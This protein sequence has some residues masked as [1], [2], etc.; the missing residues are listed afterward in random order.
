MRLRWLLVL[1]CLL[2]PAGAE[3]PRAV[4]G[5]LQGYVVPEGEDIFTVARKFHL[6]VDHLAYANGFPVTTIRVAP[7]T[8]LIVPTWRVL[9]A[10]CP[11]DGLVVN[12]PERGLYVFE[13]G[14]FKA[15]YAISIGDESFQ[16]GRF[17][18]PTGSFSVAEKIANPTWYPPAWAP[19]RTPVGPGP[20]NPLGERWIGLTLPRVGIHGTSDPLNIGNSL[21][22]G[23]IRMYP[24]LIKLVYDDVKVGWPVRIEYETAKV[25]KT[26]DGKLVTVTFPDVYQRQNPTKAIRAALARCG[27]K[28][29]PGRKNFEDVAALGLGIPLQLDRQDS[30]AEEICQRLA[31]PLEALAP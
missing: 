6:A 24:E 18:T 11:R 30:V 7:G 20:K 15:F 2:A 27:V 9:P 16:G 26:S 3:A 19:D 5:Q 8:H 25:G 22:H 31:W 13:G 4:V 21:T 1:L 29:P 14:R 28:T 12:L 10:N 23:C 17:R